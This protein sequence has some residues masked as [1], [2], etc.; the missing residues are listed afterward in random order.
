[1][2]VEWGFEL[3]SIIN[4][5]HFGGLA[6]FLSISH[7]AIARRIEFGSLDIP[8][9][10]LFSSTSLVGAHHQTKCIVF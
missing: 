5:S 9:M 2:V 3:G 7:K 1:M 4:T 10:F 6:F 8:V